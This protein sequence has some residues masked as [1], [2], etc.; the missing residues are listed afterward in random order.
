MARQE[1]LGDWIPGQGSHAQTRGEALVTHSKIGAR[2]SAAHLKFLHHK[3]QILSRNFKWKSGTGN[4]GFA[5]VHDFP[6][7]VKGGAE[8]AHELRKVGT[9]FLIAGCLAMLVMMPPP[10]QA[11]AKIQHLI[12]R[13]E[14]R[15]VG[16]ECRSRW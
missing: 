10:S 12:S 14:E 3:R 15:R 1:T 6:K 5:S 2:A 7:F 11:A 13:S 16:K 8:G 4:Y 9:R